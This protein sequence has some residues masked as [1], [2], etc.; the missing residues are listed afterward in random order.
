MPTVELP[1]IG[2]VHILKR[3]SSRNLSLSI[4]AAGQIRL[5]IPYGV[6]QRSA[7]HFVNTKKEWILAHQQRNQVVLKPGDP[8]GKAHRLSFRS[9]TGLSRPS[10]R[11]VG[12]DIRV[13]LPLHMAF[14]AA[15]AQSVATRTAIRALREQANLLLPQRLHQLADQ[16]G[17]TLSS[18][19]VRHMKS[20]WGSC[21]HQ[22]RISL[23][24]FLMQLPW[25]LID[26]VILHE[27]LHTKIL[28]HGPPFWEA[29]ERLLPEAKVLRK[30]I[31]QYQAILVATQ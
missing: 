9:Q 13:A 14:D 6:S 20:R 21:T 25:E 8:I 17:F 5:S 18:V 29:F 22:Q 15:A 31:K 7:L 4:N 19:S 26:Y 27:L 28:R 11:L 12:S 3:R 23:N 16:Y 2:L 10:G 1:Q 30:Q 24:L